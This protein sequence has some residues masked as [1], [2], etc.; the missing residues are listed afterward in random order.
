MM[1]SFFLMHKYKYNK[2]YIIILNKKKNHYVI[3]III[4]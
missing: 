3:G 2:K 1:H 4:L